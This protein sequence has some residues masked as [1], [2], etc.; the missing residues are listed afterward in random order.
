MFL[1]HSANKPPDKSGTLAPSS[2]FT[3][4]QSNAKQP[5]SVSYSKVHRFA[6]K[7]Q[8]SLVHV[9]NEPSLSPTNS[10][11]EISQ[12]AVPVVIDTVYWGVSQFPGS[13]FFDVTTRKESERTLYKLAFYQFHYVVGQLVHKSGANRYLAI[14]SDNEE[15]KNEAIAKSLQLD[16]R[17]YHS[18]RCGPHARFYY[19]KNKSSET[20]LASTKRTA[21][22]IDCY[23]QQ[24]E[25]ST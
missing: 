24:V 1:S 9:P 13:L 20:F 16:N 12:D 2:P 18:S 22:R 4:S 15:N 21:G 6:T 25:C 10:S 5:K 11:T 14:N 19:Q 7:I 8:E 3:S 17:H 23:S